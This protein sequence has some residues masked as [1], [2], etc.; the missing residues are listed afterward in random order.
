MSVERLLVAGMGNVLRGDD[1]FGVA[2]ACA[3]AARHLPP[4]V[5]VIEVGIGGIHVVQELFSGYDALVVIDAVDRG[6]E[7]G[8]VFLLEPRVPVLDPLSEGGRSELLADM[9]YAV[10]S[11]ALIMARAL[12]VL[13]RRAWILGCQPRNSHALGLELSEPVRAAVPQA[14]ARLE[15]LIAELGLE[16]GHTPT[17]SREPAGGDGAASSGLGPEQRRDAASKGYPE[18]RMET[19]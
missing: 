11:K 5:K 15:R 18:Q 1:G 16:G 4:A 9:H 6:A 14:V 8:T 3:L 10:P 2:V 12:G 7:P 13:P 17:P 19:T